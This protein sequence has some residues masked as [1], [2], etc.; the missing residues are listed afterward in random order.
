[1][2]TIPLIG[3]QLKGFLR[4][5]RSIILLIVFPLMLISVLFLSFNP[6]G[7]QR[8]PLG[9][10]DNARVFDIDEYQAE[11]F[12]YFHIVK[13]KNI[14]T[15]INYMKQY[16]RYACFEVISGEAITIKV[17]YDNTREPIIWEILER[18]K[19]G[20]EAIQK[21]KSR[22]IASDFLTK[23]SNTKAKL[24]RFQGDL[25]R[26]SNRIDGYISGVDQAIVDMR[27]GKNDLSNSLDAMDQDI[28]EVETEKNALRN[29]KNQFYSSMM[30]SIYSFE[31]ALYLAGLGGMFSTEIDELRDE[32]NDYNN[33]ANRKF[34]E[35]DSKIAGYKTKSAQGRV[36]VRNIES[37]IQ[38]LQTTRG[39]LVQY[40]WDISNLNNEIVVIQTDFSALE[41][42]SAEELVNPIVLRNYPNYIPEG[43]L[44][45]IVPS[46][47]MAR[48]VTRGFNL[49]TLQT[50]FPK[51]LI[52][53]ALFLSLLIS[54]F[55]CVNE[56]NSPAKKRI[57]IIRRIFFPEFI[58]VYASSLIIVS[59]PLFCVIF[60]G[61]YLFK[62]NIL[63]NGYSYLILF[64]LSSVFILIGLNLSYL[65]KKESTTIL[66][67]TF[68]LV[69]LLFFSG[70]VLPIERM[71]TI[72]YLIAQVFPGNLALAAFN[73]AVF[74]G[75]G[76][77]SFGG[78]IFLLFF[79]VLVLA[80]AAVAVKKIRKS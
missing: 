3:A 14:D 69:L 42:V 56:I 18:I 44:D 23:F 62:L 61:N 67:S 52:L 50:I 1:M 29:R 47:D 10:T 34:S 45:E 48:Q 58:A 19:M 30:N 31:N 2:K 9:I 55:I 22:E 60:L 12:P 28:R 36:Y 66:V 7:L 38:D 80:A 77:E 54:S 51:M 21:E 71:S 35:I 40:K 15:C 57:N 79:W 53:I 78:I 76:M 72:S 41:G 27:Q 70:F 46:K 32:V 37:G 24:N 74:Y 63:G 20:V 59:L 75:M 43:S 65:I 8:I 5:W 64:L 73:Q 6:E 13:Y 39:Q 17:Y 4:N 68:M 33:D 25:G 11:Y 49:I 26:V 16:K